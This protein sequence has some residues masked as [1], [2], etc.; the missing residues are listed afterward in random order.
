MSVSILNKLKDVTIEQ[1]EFTDSES[2]EIIEYKE[3]ALEVEFDGQTET[4]I[5]KVAKNEGKA[6]Y[7]LLQLADDQN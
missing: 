3:I 6:A 7:R 5:A 1:R 4:I 2:G